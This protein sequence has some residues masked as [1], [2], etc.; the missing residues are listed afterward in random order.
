MADVSEPPVLVQ[1]R[2]VDQHM[3]AAQHIVQLRHLQP[4]PLQIGNDRRFLWAEVLSGGQQPLTVCAFPGR[5]LD[6]Q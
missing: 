5:N 6:H 3:A 2:V 4:V 1:L